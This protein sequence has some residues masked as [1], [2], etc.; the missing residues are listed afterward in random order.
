MEWIRRHPWTALLVW[1]LLTTAGCVGA[2]IAGTANPGVWTPPPRASIA[3]AASSVASARPTLPA[4]TWA[5]STAVVLPASPDDV[6]P[7]TDPPGIKRDPDMEVCRSINTTCGGYYNQDRCKKGPTSW[8][9]LLTPGQVNCVVAAQGLLDIR[10]RVR[11]IQ[12]C[13]PA[14]IHCQEPH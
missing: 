12:N 14:E 9:A 13:A 11:W 8:T 5:P 2:Y 4:P 1:A 10:Q 3:P 7:W 6:P